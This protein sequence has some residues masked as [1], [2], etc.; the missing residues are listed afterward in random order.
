MNDAPPAPEPLSPDMV[1]ALWQNWRLEVHREHDLMSARIGWM[2][3]FH[4]FSFSAFAI[5]AN[6]FIS[7]YVAEVEQS[8]TARLM[9]NSRVDDWLTVAL[10]IIAFAGIFVTA[11]AHFLVRLAIRRL[12]RLDAL[13]LDPANVAM[14]THPIIQGLNAGY[15]TEPAP[16][17]RLKS[18][19]TIARKGVDY[20][21][22]G[23]FALFYLVWIAGALFA[24]DLLRIASR[25]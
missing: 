11:I 7:N 1:L 18:Y 20:V 25:A 19:D 16:G 2:L 22:F 17:E 8:R 3:A 4:S 10:V 12:H 13:M 5:L 6:T 15:W 9:A 14:R 24:L 23:M 21:K